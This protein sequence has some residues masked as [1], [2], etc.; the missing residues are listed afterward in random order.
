MLYL[1]K[2]LYL[3][4][5]PFLSRVGMERVGK[6]GMKLPVNFIR[7]HLSSDKGRRRETENPS[8]TETTS[9][10]SVFSISP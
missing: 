4:R 10:F 6:R 8:F 2:V 3:A 7:V 1:N 5:S 9:Y